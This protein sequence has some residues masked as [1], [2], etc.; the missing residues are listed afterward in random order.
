[1]SGQPELLAR[2]AGQK[3]PLL[4]FRELQFL[5]LCCQPGQHSPSSS[6]GGEER[7]K[8]QYAAQ[9]AA[10]TL[11]LQHPLAKV[12][13]LRPAVV[14]MPQ[15][16]AVPAPAPGASG[17]VFRAGL[18]GC[19]NSLAELPYFETCLYQEQTFAKAQQQGHENA[20]PYYVWEQV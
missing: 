1:M 9:G 10:L 7:K 3:A 17:G 20:F 5:S 8:Q 13:M 6:K 2:A 11:S 15:R 14:A 12:G 4:P 19:H 16:P 18:A